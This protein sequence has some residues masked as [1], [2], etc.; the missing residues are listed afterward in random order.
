MNRRHRPVFVYGTLRPG[1]GNYRYLLA[2]HATEDRP[3]RVRGYALYGAGFPYAVR[4][5]GSVIQGAV[6]WIDPAAYIETLEGL[7][8]LE[9]FRPDR[10]GQSHYVR[11]NVS[12]TCATPLPGGGTYET[13]HRVWM[14]EAGPRF[15]TDR[16]SRIDSGDWVA[17]RSQ[18][19][20][21]TTHWG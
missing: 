13:F 21:R 18:D 20:A 17:E 12:A 15:R 19:R 10:P 6:V 3:A 11:V 1:Q 16:H 9:G 14:Y 5:R 8:R 7:D 2:E 4:E